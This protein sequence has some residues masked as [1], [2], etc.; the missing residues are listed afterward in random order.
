[1][2]GVGTLVNRE[3]YVQGRVRQVDGSDPQL[4]AHVIG[5]VA[6]ER[7]GWGFLLEYTALGQAA[8]Q[9]GVWPAL[10]ARRLGVAVP[11]P[12]GEL[13]AAVEEA[14]QLLAA[15]W[16]DWVWQFVMFKARH[17]VGT[18]LFERPRPA[19]WME[20]AVRLVDLFPLNVVPW[21]VTV[22][23]RNVFELVK[24]L[25]LEESELVPR[26]LNAV[27]VG[28]QTFCTAHDRQ[29]AEAISLSFSQLVGRLY[30]AK[31]ESRVGILAVP[32]AVRIAAHVP[33]GVSP[34]QTGEAYRAACAADPRAN[35]DTRL[36]VL[37]KIDPRVKYDPKAMS[38]AAWER[39]KLDGPQEFF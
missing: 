4:L 31:L 6:A 19:R 15:G 28:T 35:P 32:H 13:A 1:M 11:T 25:F 26:T 12:E 23:V 27:I 2:P 9:A 7:W 38:I 14:W 21:G 39:F 8:G 16:L 29:V 17:P 22:R 34:A 3:H 10:R 37:S 5:E 36:A 30:F 18:Q 24:F 33:G 20:L